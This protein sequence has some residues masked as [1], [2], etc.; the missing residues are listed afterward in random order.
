MIGINED[1][2]VLDIFECVQFFH[3]ELRSTMPVHGL[4]LQFHSKFD[5]GISNGLQPS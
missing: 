4:E 5:N 3:P 1:Q 2:V